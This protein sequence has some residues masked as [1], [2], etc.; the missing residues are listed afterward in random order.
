MR[1]LGDSHIQEIGF[2]WEA[3]AAVI[4]RALEAMEHG[5]CAQP[6]KPYLRYGDTR[7][8]II[9][10]PAYVGGEIRMAGLKWIASFPGNIEAGLPRAHSV[11][12]L[13]DAATGVPA[14][15]LNSPAVSG[16]RTAA[17]SGLLLKQ[18][19]SSRPASERAHR[20]GIIGWG[21]IGRFHFDMCSKWFGDCIEKLYVYDIRG[22]DF[23]LA[24]SANEPSAIQTVAASSWEELYAACNVIINCTVSQERYIG[25][26]PSP[27][28]LLLDVSLRDFKLEAIQGIKAVIVD[29]WTEVCR[30]NT[31]IELLHRES[32]LQQD[33]VMTLEEVVLRDALKRIDTV[34]D[35]VLFCPM[36][37]AVF[38]VA[39]ADWFYRK[40][41]ELG[42]GA[43]L[44]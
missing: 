20:I 35:P 16:A 2:H 9:A 27:G 42:I 14:A 23:R 3:L 26:P 22:V 19:L 12:I 10:M 6:L 36:G 25:L 43:T 5:D 37:M 8:R 31:D 17:V 24:P 7:N 15:M 44:D 28:T 1:Y 11:T 30:E 32:G 34:K 4:Q 40:S 21:P 18:W 41:L 33:A 29:D 39:V 38:D 13:N